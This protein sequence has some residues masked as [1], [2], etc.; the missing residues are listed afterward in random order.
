MPRYYKYKRYY[1]KLFP[2][3][4]WATNI[5]SDTLDVVLN[6]NDKTASRDALICRNAV[7]TD[8]PTP[9]I[10][11]AGRFK[12]KGDVRFSQTNVAQFTSCMVYCL[13][14]PEGATPEILLISNHPEYLL[15]WTS[16]SLDSGST[17]SLTTTLK[18]NLN[19]GDSIYL[20]FS[21]D[22]TT[23]PSQPIVYNIFYTA[24]FWTTSG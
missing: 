22:T 5:T 10:L 1:K 3:K 14:V 17:F 21:F 20:L 19:S 23:T 6:T 9:V 16:I 7:Q 12:I 24:Q 4:K 18:R 8:Y 13:F 11:K 15:G 2:K